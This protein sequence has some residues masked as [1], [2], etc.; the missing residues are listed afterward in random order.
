MSRLPG[1]AEE[2]VIPYNEREN[3]ILAH[4]MDFVDALTRGLAGM[5]KKP[6]GAPQ[7]GTEGWEP[8]RSA[9]IHKELSSSQLL[10]PDPCLEA[11]PPPCS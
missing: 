10:G 2:R 4:S 6:A 9:L 3:P 1:K 11:W 7:R 8:L 5:G